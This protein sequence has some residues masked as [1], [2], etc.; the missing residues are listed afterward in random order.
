MDGV[1]K[2]LRWWTVLRA[3]AVFNVVAWLV[4]AATVELGRGAVALQLGLSFFYVMVC[5]FRSF[6]PRIDLER[7]CMVDSAWSSMVVGRAAATV[8]E[9]SFGAQVGLVVALVGAAAGLG[10]VAWLGALVVGLLAVAQG[11]CWWSV[12]SLS[13]LGHAIEES[14]WGLTFA[15]IGVAMALCVPHLHGPMKTLAGFTVPVCG[16]YVAFMVAV[17]VPMYVRRWREGRAAGQ[18]TLGL[19]E[20]FRDA[21]HRREVTRA[22]TV[23]KPEVAWLT[24]YF[25][26]AVWGSLG[27]VHVVSALG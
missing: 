5:G 4:T 27:L 14:L 18:Q 2:T 3:I 16:L 24:G 17:D 21:L 9:V 6:F 13:H 11:F 23:W 15:L 26:V 25:S 22:W 10:W 7:T 19:R 1:E 8:A 12:V 20:G